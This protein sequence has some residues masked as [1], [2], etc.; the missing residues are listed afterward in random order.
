[1]NVQKFEPEDYRNARF[2]VGPKLVRYMHISVLCCNSNAFGLESVLNTSCKQPYRNVL[3]AL[4]V[5]SVT[6]MVMR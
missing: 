3:L 6:D 1:M 4:V 2:L 5:P